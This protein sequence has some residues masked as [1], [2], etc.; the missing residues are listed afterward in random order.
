MVAPSSGSLTSFTTV[1]STHYTAT[2]N[3]PVSTAA[4]TIS[5][6]VGGFTD[7]AGNTG[8][9]SSSTTVAVDT[10]AP[11]APSITSIAEN[12]GGGINA[13]EASDG[14]PVVVSLTGTGSAEGDTLTVNWG[15]QTLNH[16]L[17]ASD[18]STNSATVMVPTGTITTQGNGTFNVTAKLTDIAGNA[19]ANSDATLVKVDTVAPTV[20]SVVATGSGITSGTGDLD[21]GHVVTLTV[22]TSENVTVAGGTPT[23]T[24]NDGG[25]R[26]ATPPTISPATTWSTSAVWKPAGRGNTA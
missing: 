1:D 19:S 8:S 14:T 15:V 22:N 23:L 17:T 16:T 3:P 25:T 10:V 13:S 18:V 12:A 9:V 4:G 26:A 24:L 5:F 11:I 20:S 6:T 21:A 7:A 2:L